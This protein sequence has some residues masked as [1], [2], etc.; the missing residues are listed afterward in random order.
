MAYHVEGEVLLKS[1]QVGGFISV[2][3]RQD[4]KS[5]WCSTGAKSSKK[6][7]HPVTKDIKVIATKYREF[8]ATVSL[9]FIVRTAVSQPMASDGS[10]VYTS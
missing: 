9:F 7:L 1:D 8:G 2:N 6:S 5:V 10:E 4:G 3:K